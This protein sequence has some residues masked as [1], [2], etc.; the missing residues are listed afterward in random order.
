MAAEDTIIAVSTARGNAPRAV[1]RLS[2]EQAVPAVADRFQPDLDAPRDWRNTF[3]VTPG[4]LALR[5]EGVPVPV[6]T[7]V[8]RA[9]RSYTCEDVVEIHLPG[10]QALLDMV[11]DEFLT[12]A[13]VRVA[14]PGEFT[15]RAFMNGRID[16]AQAEA[17]LAIIRA[18][19]NA[20]LLA[21]TSKLEGHASKEAAEIQ[22]E[23]AEIRAQVEA[24]LDFDQHGITIISR[25]DVLEGLDEI[26]DRLEENLEGARD[27][28]ASDGTTHVVICGPPNAGKS[29]LLNRL[30]GSDRA[31][32]NPQPGTTRDPV[33]TRIEVHGIEFTVSDTAGM[34]TP[35]DALEATATDMTDDWLARAQLVMLVLDASQPISGDAEKLIERLPAEKLLLV[36]NKCDLPEELD[37]THLP[38]DA[39][40]ELVHTSA[41]TGEG[42][43]ELRDALGR[44]ITEGKLDASAAECL[45]NARQRDALRRA[46]EHT[47]EA[48]RA[49]ESGVGYEFLALHLREINDDLGEIS[50]QVTS[51]DVLDRIFSQFCIGK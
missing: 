12:G 33:T 9:P 24:A 32:V 47:D 27:E 16:L 49:T 51:D 5:R 44:V 43:D 39:V 15:Q 18:R 25:E 29:S 42:M 13:D 4:K 20:E 45:F 40:G 36:L 37:E 8:M 19:S 41:L 38:D 10:S 35:G 50:G 46:L 26:E 11:M 3:T 34:R 22:S 23:V 7:Y 21:A 17:V 30:A 31:I 2:G 14:R 28:L 1:I 6:L 48:R